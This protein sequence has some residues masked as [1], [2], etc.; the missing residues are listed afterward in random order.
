[1]TKITVEDIFLELYFGSLK[2][3]KDFY[4]GQE[5]LTVVP[6]MK[7]VFI[8]RGQ[9]VRVEFQKQILQIEILVLGLY[10]NTAN[11]KLCY[12]RF[13]FLQT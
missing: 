5:F 12:L 10:L 1:M 8:L 4:R 9:C 2:R 7:C 13:R 6:A 11:T 3:E